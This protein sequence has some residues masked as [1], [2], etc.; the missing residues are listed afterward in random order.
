MQWIVE[1]GSPAQGGVPVYPQ[2]FLASSQ[3]ENIGETVPVPGIL[4]S[5]GGLVRPHPDGSMKLMAAVIDPHFE[6]GFKWAFS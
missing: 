5:I 1:P 2:D 6:T 3:Q 4:F